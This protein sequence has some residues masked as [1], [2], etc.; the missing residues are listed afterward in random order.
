MGRRRNEENLRVR[1]GKKRGMDEREKE[2]G[3]KGTEKQGGK[4][5]EFRIRHWKGGG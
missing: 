2:G 5:R 4:K 3:E 1:S